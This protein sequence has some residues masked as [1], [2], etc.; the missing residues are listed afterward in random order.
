[1]LVSTF[2]V[3]HTMSY[4][5]NAH[6]SKNYNVD[7]KFLITVYYWYNYTPINL[8]DPLLY[9]LHVSNQGNYN[10]II[11]MTTIL[12]IVARKVWHIIQLN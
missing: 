1:M 10:K 2:Y 7:L 9:L 5:R 4:Q 6:Q 3:P 12:N 11:I 8:N